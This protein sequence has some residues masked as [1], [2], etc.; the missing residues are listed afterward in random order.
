VSNIQP[1]ELSKAY[2]QL[3]LNDFSLV[4]DN[5]HNLDQHEQ[6]GCNTSLREFSVN[7]NDTSETIGKEQTRV[8]MNL[9]VLGEILHQTVHYCM[10]Y[11]QEW[12]PIVDAAYAQLKLL[13]D[14]SEDANAWATSKECFNVHVAS[15]LVAVLVLGWASRSHP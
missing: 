7:L 10:K 3:V 8:S 13:Q 9:I 5:Y 14:S 2:R 11:A 15:M 12:Y 1:K 6:R 4:Q